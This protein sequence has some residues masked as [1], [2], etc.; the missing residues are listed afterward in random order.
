MAFRSH[1]EN[2]TAQTNSR[3]VALPSP[4][5]CD[6]RAFSSSFIQNLLPVAGLALAV[7]WVIES[8]LELTYHSLG[9]SNRYDKC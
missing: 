2:Q 3:T 6:L 4:L 7:W 5:N 9:H 1:L 8:R